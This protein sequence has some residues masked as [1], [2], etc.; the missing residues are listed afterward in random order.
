MYLDKF[1]RSLPEFHLTTMLARYYMDKH[2]F[3]EI[4]YRNK[5]GEMLEY[6]PLVTAVRLN[7][8]LP[9]ITKHCKA[10]TFILGNSFEALAQ[11][12]EESERLETLVI[13]NITDTTIL[14]LWRNPQDVKNIIDVFADLKHLLLS[15]RR[16]EVDPNAIVNFERRLWEM[17]EKA[18]ELQSLCLVGQDL[19]WPFFSPVKQTTQAYCSIQQWTQ[20]TFPTIRKPPTTGLQN[21]TSLELSRMEICACGLLCILKNTRKSLQA[22]CLNH[23]YLKTVVHRHA[24]LVDCE[25]VLWIGLPNRKPHPDHRWIATVIRQ[26]NLQLRT[27]RVTSIGYDQYLDGIQFDEMPTYDLED[28]CGLER[29]FEQRFVEVALGIK[30]PN[31]VDGSPV[32]YLP[33][34]EEMT[35]AYARKDPPEDIER[36]DW[37]AATYP[38]DDN[39]TSIWQKTIDRQFANRNHFTLDQLNRFAEKAKKGMDALRTVPD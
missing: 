30:Q 35:W 23:V 20:K 24:P 18:R 6:A 34:D 17:I 33:E 19:S 8:P 4:D 39:Y 5:L 37:D 11:R 38:D 21:L 2:S 1:F 12:P 15:V 25:S 36:D 7:L 13:D 31:A 3:T 22:L 14:S 26:M 9:L 10:A 29:S 32:Q 28:P 27:C 16:L